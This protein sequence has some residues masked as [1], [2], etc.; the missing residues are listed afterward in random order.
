MIYWP[1]DWGIFAKYF[2]N[3]GLLL[4]CL[5]SKFMETKHKRRVFLE[6]KQ[7]NALL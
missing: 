7:N 3:G 1:L 4:L 5:Y 6:E 2:E